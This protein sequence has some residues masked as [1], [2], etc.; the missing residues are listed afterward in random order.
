M[1]MIEVELKIVLKGV[2]TFATA[3][4]PYSNRSEGWRRG[5]LIKQDDGR[6]SV[7]NKDG[8]ELI[9]GATDG[10]LQILRDKDMLRD[11]ESLDKMYERLFK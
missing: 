1:N 8:N 10:M 7:I 2:K 5:N 9:K 4:E 3:S 11:C 6:F